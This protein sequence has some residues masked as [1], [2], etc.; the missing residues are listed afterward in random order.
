MY[1]A[2]ALVFP[3]DRKIGNVYLIDVYKVRCASILAQWYNGMTRNQEVEQSNLHST[4]C[5]SVGR[6]CLERVANH[7][8]AL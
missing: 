7:I 1:Q 3:I 6:P 5:C 4:N 2:D 8:N